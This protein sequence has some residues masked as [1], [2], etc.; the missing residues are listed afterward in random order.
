MFSPF[1]WAPPL[2]HIPDGSVA[3]RRVAVDVRVGYMRRVDQRVTGEELCS[4]GI[5][6]AHRALWSFWSAC[7]VK[8]RAVKTTNRAAARMSS[9]FL[10]RIW[11]CGRVL[12]ILSDLACDHGHL[13][14]SRPTRLGGPSTGG[15]NCL[16]GAEVPGQHRPIG[17]YQIGHVRRPRWLRRGGRRRATC[18]AGA[19]GKER[20]GEDRGAHSQT[21]EPG[22]DKS[23]RA[24]VSSSDTHNH[25]K[26]SYDN[27]EETAPAHEEHVA[28]FRAEWP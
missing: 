1:V 9:R 14:Q 18:T 5:V 13:V 26:P 20:A 23:R 27:T 12:K 2:S 7:F 15:V 24:D 19:S 8:A 22:V 3:F 28:P 6:V 16:E 4:A 21:T 10:N 25:E 17:A 11:F